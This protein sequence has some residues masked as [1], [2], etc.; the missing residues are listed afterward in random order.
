M[1]PV[2]T[3]SVAIWA[4]ALIGQL[5]LLTMAVSRAADALVRIAATLETMRGSW[6]VTMPIRVVIEG[7]K[8]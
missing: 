8:P 5:Y 1:N 2:L 4:L 7:V 3:I 6:A